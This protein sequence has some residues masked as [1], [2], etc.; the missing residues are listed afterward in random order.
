MRGLWKLKEEALDCRLWRTRI[1]RGYV[2]VVWQTME[3]MKKH[4]H[5][6]THARAHTHTHTHT[7]I[8]AWT[9]W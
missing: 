1:G 6:R 8:H 5:A 9:P 3:W 2:P 7:H 4:T